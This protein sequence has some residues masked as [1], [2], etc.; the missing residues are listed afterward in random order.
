MPTGSYH[1]AFLRSG[2]RHESSANELPILRRKILVTQAEKRQNAVAQFNAELLS[3]QP[4]GALSKPTPSVSNSSAIDFA[5]EAREK[6]SRTIIRDN[7]EYAGLKSLHLSQRASSIGEPS[8]FD[9]S[10]TVTGVKRFGRQPG[11][12]GDKFKV[13]GTTNL[14]R[15]FGAG[16]NLMQTTQKRDI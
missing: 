7:A 8:E 2:S 14:H 11:S 3:S 4:P 15:G 6:Y 16:F 1:N 9:R 5:Q 10:Q 13:S 12:L